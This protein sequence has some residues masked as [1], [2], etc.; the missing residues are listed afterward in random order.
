MNANGRHGDVAGASRG[1][2]EPRRVL[3]FFSAVDGMKGDGPLPA[4]SFESITQPN[5]AAIRDARYS[6]VYVETITI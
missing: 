6:R 1:F 2:D 3:P 4:V 5:G